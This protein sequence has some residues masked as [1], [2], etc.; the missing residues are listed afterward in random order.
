MSQIAVLAL[1][2]AEGDDA[3][4]LRDLVASHPVLSNRI[5]LKFSRPDAAAG[6]AADA[7]VIVC[8]NL[9][10]DILKAAQRLKW[11][12]FWSAGLD[13]KISPEMLSRPLLVTNASGVHGP[14]IAE[15][16]LA[17]MLMFTRKMH[18]HLRSQWESAWDMS[19]S[20]TGS[21]AE[22]LAGQTLGIV[23]VGRIGEALALR[24][25]GMEMRVIGVKRDAAVR[26]DSQVTLD[27]FYP[28]EELPRLLAESDHVCI[29]V[30]STPKTH[31]LFDRNLLG[32]MKKSAYLYNIARGQ[33]IDEAALVEVLQFGGIA[34][35]GLDVFEHE[36]LSPDSPL[37]KMENVLITPHVA[38]QTP[39]YFRRFASLFAEN[40]TRYL[41]K[42]PLHN[43]FDASRG[44]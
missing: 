25:R 5:D 8:G 31:H 28:A 42:E 16:V 43:L 1:M 11:A 19:A 40:L 9:P 27:A 14:N 15:H 44:Y 34:G 36:P 18:L 22:E 4:I 32:H 33:V 12:A 24:A 26:H 3:R 29:A 20:R 21:Q 17:W 30:P 41:N 35:V 7:E 10:R 6:M 37:W 13:G 38:G 23:G 2:D 39:Y